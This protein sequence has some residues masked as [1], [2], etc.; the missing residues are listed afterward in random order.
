MPSSFSTSCPVLWLQQRKE[1][2]RNFLPPDAQDSQQRCQKG[3]G[4][5]L[6]GDVDDGD[7]MSD[8]PAASLPASSLPDDED[9]LE[10]ILLR[11]PPLPSSLPRASLVSKL[12][13]RIISDPTFRRRFRTHHHKTPPLLGFFF[14]SFG[15]GLGP[16]QLVFTPTLNAPD[17]IPTARFSCPRKGHFLG[18]RHGLALFN[19][20]ASSKAVVWDPLTNQQCSIEFP[21]EF[22]INHNVRIYFGAVLKADPGSSAFKFKLIMVFYSVFERSLHASVYES[23]S[24]KWGEIISQRPSP[25]AMAV[26]RM[27]EDGIPVLENVQALRTK[28]GGLGFAV[29][30]KKRMQLWG[31]TSISGDVVTGVLEKTVELDQLLPLRPLSPETERQPSI[32]G[33]DE[34]TNIIF[35]WTNVGV[36]MIKLESMEFTKVSE[37]TCIP[38]LS[39]SNS[40]G[41]NY[42]AAS[43]QLPTPT[44]KVD[45]VIGDVDDLATRVRSEGPAS[46]LVPPASSVLDDEDIL[47]QILLRLPPLPS[48]LPRASLVS[49]LWHSITSDPGF[50]RRFRA[51]HHKA[52]PL[53]GFFF[54]NFGNELGRPRFVFNPTLSAPNRIPPARFSCPSKGH[55]L[56]CRHGLAL[57]NSG[58]SSKAVVWDPLTNQQCS[59]DFPPEFNVN[60]NVRIYFG[61]V[62]RDDPSSTEFKFKIVMVL[63]GVFERSLHASMYESD[64]GKWGEIISTATFSDCN[65]PSVLVG[66]KIYWLIR[67]H[68][69]SRFLEYDVDRQAM[70][71]I[72]MPEDNIHFPDGSHVQALRT[73]DGGLGFAVL[74]KKR[75]QLW[76]KTSISGNVVTGVLEKTVE[77]DQLL[78]LRPPSTEMEEKLSIVGYDE[79][80]NVIF[81][82]TNVGVFMIKLESMEFTKQ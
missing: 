60:H 80:N 5:F 11:L 50:R 33:Y 32:V 77:L 34:D 16:A 24:G 44:H 29:V 68:G 64:S 39:S 73:K 3:A 61:A 27:S 43:S 46:A 49:K 75:M 35:L 82:W 78:P 40:S 51:H 70:A 12:W 28:D 57:F 9:I 63:C 79:E 76:G 4:H 6:I 38:V 71:V 65:M 54:E 19:S 2:P 37:D 74:W 81:L 13:H 14:E 45:I 56:G 47:G 58:S 8:G 48:S 72:K 10:Q 7:E 41:R 36:F 18:C 53:L 62:L 23:D 31:K 17:R 66:N 42:L 26:I 52:P 67:F 20:G 21:P 25:T 22:N 1:L 55:F 15:D 69:G 59:I 30:W